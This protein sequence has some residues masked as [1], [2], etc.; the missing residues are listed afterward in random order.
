MEDELGTMK[1][2]MN[3]ENIRFSD[4]IDFQIE[5][6]DLYDDFQNLTG[7]KVILKIPMISNVR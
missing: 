4:E 6:I 1:L 5:I 7:I 2:Y 3:I